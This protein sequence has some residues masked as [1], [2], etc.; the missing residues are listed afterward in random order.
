ML[1]TY[2]RIRPK[3]AREEQL[4]ACGNSCIGHLLLLGQGRNGDH[5][6]HGVLVHQGLGE[7]LRAVVAPDDLRAVG[8]CGRR[9]LT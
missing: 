5:A 7:R 9:V 1:R 4:D 6:D 3:L 2:R 8:E